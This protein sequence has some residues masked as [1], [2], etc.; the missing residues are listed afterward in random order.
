MSPSW[1]KYLR[2]FARVGQSDIGFLSSDPESPSRI[3]NSAS[4]LDDT[5]LHPVDR[6]EGPAEVASDHQQ[7]GV[8][9]SWIIDRD[10]HQV[11]REGA[12]GTRWIAGE[13]GV[14]RTTAYADPPMCLGRR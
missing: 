9:A 7:S 1:L 4:P 8:E 11:H 3:A 5:V 13:M 10:A 6:A 2:S 12:F 14:F